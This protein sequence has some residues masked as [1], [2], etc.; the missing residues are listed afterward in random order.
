MIHDGSYLH[1]FT[2]IIYHVQIVSN[3]SNHLMINPSL[4]Y[5]E[6]TGLVFAKRN[7]HGNDEPGRKQ[8]CVPHS[9]GL[10]WQA[11]R[12]FQAQGGEKADCC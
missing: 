5:L 2:Y 12:R 9:V 1:D 7:G 4:F 6:W 3:I 8:F 10:E 11:E